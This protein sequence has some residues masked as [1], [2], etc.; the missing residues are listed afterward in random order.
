[1]VDLPA[2]L[3]R[4]RAADESGR[5]WRRPADLCWNFFFFTFFWSPEAVVLAAAAR[6]S[7]EGSGLVAEVLGGGFGRRT[8]PHS[9][10]AAPWGSSCAVEK[11]MIPIGIELVS[12]FS[13]HFFVLSFFQFGGAHAAERVYCPSCSYCTN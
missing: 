12:F 3:R 11:E 1:M 6:Q 8:T 7:H 4:R 13:F 9:M 10:G 2:T 5:H